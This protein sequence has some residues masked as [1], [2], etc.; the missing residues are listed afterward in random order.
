MLILF[1]ID[2]TL[3]RTG[4]AGLDAMRDA[5]RELF[6]EQFTL[7]G[8]EFAGRIDSVI[9]ED[10]AA[11]NGIADGQRVHDR[12]RAAYGRHLQCRLATNPTSRL[13]PG[14]AQLVHALAAREDFT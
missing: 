10:L 3:L 9:W 1:D 5:G 2:G 7:E 12:F 4:G 14:A 13:L 6:G 11:L 8:V